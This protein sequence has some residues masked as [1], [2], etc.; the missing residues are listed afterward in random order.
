MLPLPPTPGTLTMAAQILA[1]HGSIPSAQEWLLAQADVLERSA[2][3]CAQAGDVPA[4]D[5]RADLAHIA[6]VA[7]AWLPSLN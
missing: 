3:L 6:R 1:A 7:A 2:L 5:V 4:G